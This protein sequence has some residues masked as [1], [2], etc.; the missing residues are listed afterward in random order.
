M[1]I[2]FSSVL[3]SSFPS[4][5]SFICNF[6]IALLLHPH[7]PEVIEIQKLKISST[8][9]AHPASVAAIKYAHLPKKGV[10]KTAHVMTKTASFSFN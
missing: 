1:S 7:Q 8:V 4:E 9:I 5:S 10:T 2:V 6:L 3:F